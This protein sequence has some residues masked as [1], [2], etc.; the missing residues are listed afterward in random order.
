MVNE[1]SKKYLPQRSEDQSVERNRMNY[2]D[3]F[4]DYPDVLIIH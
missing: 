4:S 1:A 2:V 3:D